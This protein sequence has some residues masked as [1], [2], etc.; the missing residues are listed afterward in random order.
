MQGHKKRIR[1]TSPAFEEQDL[2]TTFVLHIVSICYR[3]FDL[4]SLVSTLVL[5][6]ARCK[7]TRV[8]QQPVN[9]EGYEER[10]PYLRA[11]LLYSQLLGRFGVFRGGFGHL[12][13]RLRN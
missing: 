2:L 7:W 13:D 11:P 6:Q 4:N 12:E 5:R 1:E 3:R 10:K 8:L 9:F